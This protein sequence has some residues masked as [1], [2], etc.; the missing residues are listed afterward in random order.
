MVFQSPSGIEQNRKVQLVLAMILAGAIAIFFV[1][2]RSRVLDVKTVYRT[3]HNDCCRDIVISGSGI[4][5]GASSAPFRLS[6]MKFGLTGYVKGRFT[7][8]GIF[9]AGEETSI[10]FSGDAEKRTMSLP[11]GGRDYTFQL[12]P[13]S[14]H[15]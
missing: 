2:T 10:S 5:Y 7:K 12:A 11:I 13:S 8:A 3:Y 1:T 15:R 6:D 4:S 14:V 9:S